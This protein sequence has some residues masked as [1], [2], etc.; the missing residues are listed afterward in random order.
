M[1]ASQLM[2]IKLGEEIVEEKK[3][4]GKSTTLT[5]KT[6]NQT[7]RRINARDT[8]FGMPEWRKASES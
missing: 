7:K 1:E 4:K 2:V 8:T 6:G 5:P 3:K